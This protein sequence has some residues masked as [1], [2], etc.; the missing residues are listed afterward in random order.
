MPRR[1]PTRKPLISPDLTPMVD[2]VFL[3]IV[4]FIVVAQITTNERLDLTL[5]ELRNA[6]TVKPG[7][8]RRVILNVAPAEQE[9]AVG[10]GYLLGHRAYP[11]TDAGIGALTDRLATLVARDPAIAVTVRADRV[12]RYERVHAA[13]RACAEAGVTRVNLVA[14]HVDIAR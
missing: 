4:F 12:E 2:V 7:D 1:A 3:L 8:D 13:L 14:E 5:P 9:P 11:D 10:G 6:L